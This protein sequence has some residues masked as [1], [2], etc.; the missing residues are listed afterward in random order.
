M[1]TSYNPEMAVAQIGQLA[2]TRNR[3]VESAIA[4]TAIPFG[5]AVALSNNPDTP[6]SVRLPRRTVGLL[7]FSADLI[8]S[9][10]VNGSVNGEAIDPVTYASS[11]DATM[12]AV[13]AAI[14][15]LDG[16]KRAELDESDTDSRTIAIEVLDA[17]IVLAS[18]AVTLGSS[19]ATIATATTGAYERIR[20]ISTFTHTKENPGTGGAEYAIGD[21]VN[22]LTQGSIWVPCVDVPSLDIPLSETPEFYRPVQVIVGGADAGKFSGYPAPGGATARGLD[23]AEFVKILEGEDDTASAQLIVNLPATYIV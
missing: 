21:A 18:W 17:D 15:A 19:Q 13:V 7:V 14:A 6:N 12:D 4:M 10:V 2:D 16:V 8:A 5:R 1:Q 9:N 11:H 3:N 22:I 20:G 23:G